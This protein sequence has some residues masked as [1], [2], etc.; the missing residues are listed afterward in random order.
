[1]VPTTGID[2]LQDG[3][4]GK[5]TKS[6]LPVQ[7]S[8][9]SCSSKTDRTVHTLTRVCLVPCTSFGSSQVDT[10]TAGKNPDQALCI[11]EGKGSL[12]GQTV[13]TFV[14]HHGLLSRYTP[15]VSLHRSHLQLWSQNPP[16]HTS[17]FG[18]Q[19]GV[20]LTGSV[21]IALPLRRARAHIKRVK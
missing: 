7:R 18:Y 9:A 14:K 8:Y 21:R 20:G 11:I 13:K 17:V 5:K 2:F 3:G 15:L 6:R 16:L 1:M 19:A 10:K 12:S 4:K